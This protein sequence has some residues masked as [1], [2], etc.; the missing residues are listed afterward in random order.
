METLENML[1]DYAEISSLG[2]SR[3]KKKKAKKEVVK[4]ISNLIIKR[5]AKSYWDK[6][7]KRIDREILYGTNPI[8]PIIKEGE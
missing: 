1:N 6:E 4:R 7:Y 5:V 8:P 3:K 2:L